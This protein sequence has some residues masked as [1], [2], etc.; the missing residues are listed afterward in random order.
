MIQGLSGRTASASANMS[1]I[2]ASLRVGGVVVS[3]GGGTVDQQRAGAFAGHDPEHEHVPV[4]A[5]AERHGG[6]R[7]NPRRF[8]VGRAVLGDGFNRLLLFSLTPRTC[9]S[10]VTPTRSRPP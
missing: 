2:A 6:D 3:H 7:G 5:L 1:F 8:D 9:R 10:S 4:H